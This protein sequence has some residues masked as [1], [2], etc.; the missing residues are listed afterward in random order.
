MT[1]T[2]GTAVDSD[3]IG[4]VRSSLARA[5]SRGI[6]VVRYFYAHLFRTRPDL[7]RLFPRDLG[8]QHERLL[9]ALTHVI[10]R[11]DEPRTVAYLAQL[12]RDHRRYGITRRDYTSVGESLMAAVAEHTPRTWDERT[13]RAWRGVYRL[14]MD[15]M[16]AAA[17]EAERQSTPASWQATV[18]S[19]GLDFA[20]HTAVLKLAPD[21]DY[22][23]AA[24]QYTAV[25]H[26]LLP[27]IWRPYSLVRPEHG[28]LRGE[29][30]LHV[31]RTQ[32]SGLGTLLCDQTT[33]GHSLTLAA[34]SGI[35]FDPPG[36]G[37]LTLMAAGTGW[38]PARAIIEDQLARRPNRFIVL[39]LLARSSHHFYDQAYIGRMARH[40]GQ[41]SCQWWHPQ[42]GESPASF[43]RRFH[44]YLRRHRPHHATHVYLAGPPS[45][46]RTTADTMR[47]HGPPLSITHDRLPPRDAAAALGTH[48]ER[49]LDPPEPYWITTPPNAPH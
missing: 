37:P 18:V 49:L 14:A 44:D 24:G 33:P 11:L 27:G 3:D 31:A 19:Q 23:F 5:E 39:H 12:G 26:P 48:A 35:G 30:E 15:A 46:V 21:Q 41:L 17:A 29:L 43:R 34:P 47:D 6:H 4:L 2:G 28:H 42:H 40:H 8:E 36:E 20:G 32:A 1:T 16:L 38:A 13:E 22:P 9:A 45:F 10:N 7:R 25:H